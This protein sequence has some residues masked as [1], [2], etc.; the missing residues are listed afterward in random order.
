MSFVTL[1]PFLSSQ[2]DF[3][4]ERG[5]KSDTTVHTHSDI[6][7]FYCAM[8]FAFLVS[9]LLLYRA[10]WPQFEYLV[11][12]MFS[13]DGFYGDS[14]LELEGQVS[15]ERQ[16]KL[17]LFELAFMVITFHR[18]YW[19]CILKTAC[20]WHLVKVSYTLGHY[21]FSYY[22]VSLCASFPLISW[23]VPCAKYDLISRHIFRVNRHFSD[24]MYGRMALF[25]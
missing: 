23:L 16:I 2:R 13:R 5:H 20:Y 1:F 24:K 3:A 4:R 6:L 25:Y 21:C 14:L 17:N 10:R 22:M 9:H 19:L 12:V 15:W 18:F 7:V 8:S 11:K